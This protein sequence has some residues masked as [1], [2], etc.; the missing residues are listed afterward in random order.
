[1]DRRYSDRE[2]SPPRQHISK[3]A[4]L[5]AGI[6]IAVTSASL[7]FV[8]YVASQA[9]DRQA[10]SNE[11]RLFQHTLENQKHQ[12]IQEQ[13]KVSHSD[14]SVRNIVR[15]FDY[16]FVRDQIRGL[17]KDYSY[18]KVL[19]IA[20]GNQVFAESFEDY[21]HI[22]NRPL[23]ETPGYLP[24]VDKARALFMSNRVRIPGGYSHRSLQ[25]LEPPQYAAI[26]FIEIDDKPA[27]ATAMPIVPDQDT[28][29]LPAGQP[30]IL[31]AAKFIDDDM[32]AGLNAQLSFIDLTFLR[33]V[34]AAPE[35]PSH[36]VRDANGKPLGSFSWESRALGSSIWPTVIPIVLALSLLLAVLAFGIAWRIGRLTSSLQ[37]SERQNHHLAM[38]D[39][40]S[41]LANRLQ[42][43]R[44]L[45][46]AT[47][48]LPASPF[49]II[50]CDL[51]KFKSVNDTYGHA[52]GDTVIKAVAQRMAEIV[53]KG[54]L[55]ARL[56][57]DE[58]VILHRSFTDHGRLT[59]LSGQLIGAVEAPIPL[60]N[61]E[62]AEIGL[63]IGIVT[64]PDCGST[65]EGLMAAADDALYYSKE[66]GRG[67]A[68]F[69]RD[70]KHLFAMSVNGTE[71]D[72][73]S[74]AA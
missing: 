44:V 68:A 15:T 64:A 23:K 24:L 2:G 18:N 66:N 48:N 8:G 71:E 56:G 22:I 16:D 36:F 38:H 31:V 53:G 37:A 51:D 9:S 21:T 50:H 30:V 17:W 62:T 26:G 55:V 49:A 58:F 46:S 11:K 45:K 4:F 13:L 41:G 19:I 12:M 74:D 73:T 57:G 7:L 34:I 27:L 61:G 14:Q 43:N 63:S 59:L 39:T 70:I 60:D 40:L 33:D 3:L 69:A 5:L 20:S 47:A 72:H 6:L 28:V 54:G 52:A 1:M 10:I 67:Q 25:G 32:L 65:P 35:S 29:T 42:F